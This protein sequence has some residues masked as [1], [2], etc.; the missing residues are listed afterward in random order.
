VESLG[1]DKCLNYKSPSFEEQLIKATDGFVDIYFDNVGGHILD[2][3]LARVKQHGVI[4]ACGMISGYN[5]MTGTTLKSKSNTSTH[6][7]H[8]QT[9]LVWQDAY[10]LTCADY[11]QVI[12]MRLQIR[13]FIVIDAGIPDGINKIVMTLLDAL[14]DG[15]LK[16]DDKSEQVID[17]KFEDI[18]KTWLKL[19]EGGNQGKLVTKLV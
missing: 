6:H 4:V 17:T 9:W 10:M 7:N 12:S 2:L 18:P 15:K 13:G 16:I 1:A 19:F 3:M 11:F 8:V 14:K 5:D